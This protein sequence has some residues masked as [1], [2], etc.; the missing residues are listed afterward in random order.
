VVLARRSS[1]NRRRAVAVGGGCRR[2]AAGP[3]AT[4]K[5]PRTGLKP[6]VELNLVGVVAGRNREETQID[7]DE[8]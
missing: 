3:V 5:K 1:T 8:L 7:Y 4:E 2:R 6:E